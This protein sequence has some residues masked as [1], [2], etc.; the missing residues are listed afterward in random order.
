MGATIRAVSFQQ[1]P[2]ASAWEKV[3]EKAFRVYHFA[4]KAFGELVF[5]ALAAAGIAGV[6]LL[7]SHAV[8]SLLA[9]SCMTALMLNL[10]P[11]FKARIDKFQ[12]LSLELIARIRGWTVGEIPP[13][14]AGEERQKRRK[15]EEKAVL[16][17]EVVFP[18]NPEFLSSGLL[19]QIN[20]RSAV[21]YQI[22]DGEL[23]INL[24]Q[25]MRV[26]GGDV[27]SGEEKLK[28]LLEI[29]SFKYPQIKKIYLKQELT[30]GLRQIRGL[31]A[32]LPLFRKSVFPALNALSLE[33]TSLADSEVSTLLANLDLKVL[34]LKNCT[35]SEGALR[36]IQSR[37]VYFCYDR[38][39]VLLASNQ[40]QMQ[41]AFEEGLRE[42]VLARSETPEKQIRDFVAHLS[43]ESRREYYALARFGVKLNLDLFTT[44]QRL[45]SFL[46]AFYQGQFAV[47]ELSSSRAF[48]RD[49][50][51]TIA[52]L[53]VKSLVAK[54][55]IAGENLIQDLG[56]YLP[57][58]EKLE[59]ELA[60]NEG[61][62]QA[63]LEAL[64]ESVKT[65][66]L[67]RNHQPFARFFRLP[68]GW[69]LQVLPSEDPLRR[70]I[71]V[72]QQMEA[73]DIQELDFSDIV[74]NNHTLRELL[75]FCREKKLHTLI[76][77][78]C[79]LSPGLV[80]NT[81][82]VPRAELLALFNPEGGGEDYQGLGCLDL[83]DNPLLQEE[84]L[85]DKWKPAF[86]AGYRLRVKINARELIFQ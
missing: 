76:L 73:L 54:G 82:G 23:C 17:Q 35:F 66:V 55:G 71:S 9:I 6:A 42:K 38:E 86:P 29:L 49:F 19:D 64:P 31:E 58:L 81:D 32:F 51:E 33:N 79:H 2:E 12:R 13:P 11:R 5:V 63:F 62:P 65:V 46:S 52:G 69:K 56:R 14:S 45:Q 61:D 67:T 22:E 3:R 26:F 70:P 1:R 78:R 53:P 25:T 39:G 83:S 72:L 37:L 80:Q 20:Q 15:L 4:V 18:Q 60:G 34:E 68:E 50:F 16:L 8:M 77:N 85:F 41:A 27:A 10:G 40:E 43:K 30:E 44:E 36:K 84:A 24:S 7:A 21:K 59:Y 28:N 57:F 74:L 75:T 47:K 48:T